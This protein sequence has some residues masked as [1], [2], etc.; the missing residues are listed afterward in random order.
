[1][2]KYESDNSKS[3][4]NEELKNHLLNDHSHE[5]LADIIAKHGWSI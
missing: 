4:T 3:Y 1:M 2:L 5:E